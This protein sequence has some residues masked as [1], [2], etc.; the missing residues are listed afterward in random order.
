MGT[1]DDS[2]ED[3]SPDLAEICLHNLCNWHLPGVGVSQTGI[4]WQRVL[5]LSELVLTKPELATDP[6]NHYFRALSL[7]HLG[8]W[9][10]AHAI[11]AKLRTQGIHPRDLYEPRSILVGTDGTPRKVQ[12]EI[13]VNESK[14]FVSVEELG[15]D[16]IADSQSK[17]RKEGET[18]YC[19]IEFSFAGPTAVSENLIQSRWQI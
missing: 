18:D 1:V 2:D 10:T 12:G 7:C 19:F 16:F 9:P 14:K 15:F 5:D 8:D 17:F 6:L 13:K 4:D 3:I 11:F